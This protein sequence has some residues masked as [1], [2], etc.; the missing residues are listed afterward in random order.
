MSAAD[1]A[2]QQ[3]DAGLLKCVSSL[4]EN[5]AKESRRRLPG[6]HR[7]QRGKPK[8]CTLA[9]AD[10]HKPTWNQRSVCLW[11]SAGDG[12]FILPRRS[13]SFCGFHTSQ[14]GWLFYLIYGLMIG[15]LLLK[16]HSSPS[17]PRSLP[18]KTR[19]IIYFNLSKGQKWSLTT[20]LSYLVC[21]LNP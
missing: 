18:V 14:V 21:F 10:G 15:L 20:S 3:I 12:A 4:S 8:R 6:Y 2:E 9:W 13:S 19:M 17:F 1:P 16:G 7:K 5:A 11:I